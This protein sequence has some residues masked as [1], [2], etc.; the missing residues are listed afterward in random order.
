M[1][2]KTNS[3]KSIALYQRRHYHKWRAAVFAVLGNKC[4]RCG[5]DDGRALQID[6]V[7]GDGAADRKK[8]KGHRLRI[9]FFKHVIEN[10]ERYQILCA[11][12]NWI[13]R[14]E[15][16]QESTPRKYEDAA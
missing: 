14:V 6:H 11:N 15:E 13:K 8:F 10:P 12:C 2:L 5:F 9:K 1:S 3:A 4:A 16:R 7:H